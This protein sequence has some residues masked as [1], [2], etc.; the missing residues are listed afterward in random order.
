MEL[1]AYTTAAIS[2]ATHAV[3]SVL[4]YRSRR[5]AKALE[6]KPSVLSTLHKYRDRGLSQREVL[7]ASA[8]F[9]FAVAGTY[10]YMN[11]R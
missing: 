5:K 4:T 6:K 8:L 7:V 9:L 3:I 2:H 10:A 11:R 1:I